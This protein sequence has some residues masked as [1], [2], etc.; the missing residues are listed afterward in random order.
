MR[1]EI[2]TEIGTDEE[3]AF[4]KAGPRKKI[5]FDPIETKAAIV[6]CGGISPGL[7]DVIRSIVMQLY[8]KYGVKK[9]PGDSLW[10]QR[11]EPCQLA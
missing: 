9:H 2:P 10:I 3:L 5:F 8:Y 4:E 6:T 7:N 11:V 1:A